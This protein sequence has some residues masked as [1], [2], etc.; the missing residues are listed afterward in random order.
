MDAQGL[1]TG[2]LTDVRGISGGT[3]NVMLRFKRSGRDFV[4][5]CP[6][7]HKR[8][9]SDET[10][11]RE[12]RILTALDRTDVPHPCL[13]AA[14][15]D[16]DVL[17][18]AFY[19]MCPVDGFNPTAEWPEPLRSSSSMQHAVG[20][21]VVAA[22][23]ALGRLDVEASGLADLGRATGWLERQV[24]RWDRQL[25]SYQ[26]VPAY[27]VAELGDVGVIADWL[28]AH[29]PTEWLPGLIHGDYHFGNV[30]VAP[31]TPA[32]AAVVDWELC[33][34]GDPLLDLGHLLNRWPHPDRGASI[35]VNVRNLPS[36]P[37]ILATYRELSGRSVTDVGW[38]RV[39]AAYRL[40]ILLDGTYAR[41]LEGRAAPDLGA[42]FR[43]RSVELMTMAAT[44]VEKN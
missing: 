26:E 9:N 24:A 7:Q 32:V 25:K 39:L 14:C 12:A 40:A 13:I 42:R 44:L 1:G 41:S 15:G 37:E 21:A 33:T 20:L 22:L 11:R 5:R 35:P 10:M 38:Y 30:M 8:A 31:S 23:A 29:T 6:P 2:R 28:Q 43:L 4:L 27:S 19:L 36:D 34:V 17:G 18:A 3:Q 16:V